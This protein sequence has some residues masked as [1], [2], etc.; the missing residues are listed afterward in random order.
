[1]YGNTIYLFCLFYTHINSA[2]L[3]VGT[4]RCFTSVLASIGQAVYSYKSQKETA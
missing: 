4:Y 3:L 2:H 1:M